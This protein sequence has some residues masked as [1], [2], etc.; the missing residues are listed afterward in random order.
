MNSIEAIC[1]MKLIPP[2]VKILAK[3]S[4]RNNTMMSNILREDM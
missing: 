1:H 2:V 4:A 3:F